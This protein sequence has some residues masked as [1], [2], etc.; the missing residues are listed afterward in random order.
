MQD[1]DPWPDTSVPDWSAI[2]VRFSFTDETKT[3]PLSWAEDM[4]QRWH[5]RNPAAFGNQLAET[6][7]RWVADKLGEEPK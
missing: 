1:T 7:R 6:N 4:L 5:K 3:I 2:N